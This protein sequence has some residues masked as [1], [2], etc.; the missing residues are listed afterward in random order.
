MTITWGEF[1]NNHK[2]DINDIKIHCKDNNKYYDAIS[3]IY[4]K[5]SDE[6]M[7]YIEEDFTK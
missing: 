4:H 1:I 2:P 6:M 5:E 3:S 7:D